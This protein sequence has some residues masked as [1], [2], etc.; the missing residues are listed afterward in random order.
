[1]RRIITRRML[2]VSWCGL[3]DNV[4]GIRMGELNERLIFVWW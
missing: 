2:L 3:V 4:V 1:M